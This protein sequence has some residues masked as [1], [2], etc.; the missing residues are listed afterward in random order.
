[1]TA[2]RRSVAALALAG[3]L[4]VLVLGVR[5]G[6]AEPDAG[7]SLVSGAG[8]GVRVDTLPP[9]VL[10]VPGWGDEAEALAP[11]RERFLVAGWRAERI[12]RVEFAD[13]EGSNRAHAEAVGRA[14][15]SLRART[16]SA[17]VDVV[18]HSMGGLA[19]RRYLAAEGGGAV[20][21]VAFLGTPHRGTVVAYLAWGAGS[22]EMEPGSP[23]LD[24]LN[25]RPP[26][27]PGVEALTVRTPLDLRV[28]PGESVTLPPGGNIR[29]VE[30][31]CPTHAGL[32]DDP[33]TFRIVREFLTGG[34]ESP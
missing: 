34:N 27:P 29:N 15:D 11:L 16:G 24:S 32:L 2:R 30:V 18:A 3:A 7:A 1:M 17:T 28:L 13:P 8:G 14:V 22:E 21:R 10:L 31:C 25:A 20:R 33:E 5:H 12:F 6:P 4:L 19:V 23:F 9:P 26:V